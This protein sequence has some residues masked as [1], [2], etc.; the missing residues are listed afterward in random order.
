[1]ISLRTA[2]FSG[3]SGILKF[4]D[5]SNDRGRLGYLIDNFKNGKLKISRILSQ[6]TQ[7]CTRILTIL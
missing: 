4:I 1:M 7:N 5:N 2:D 3:A 6:I